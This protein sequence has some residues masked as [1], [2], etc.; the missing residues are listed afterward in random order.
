MTRDPLLQWRH[1]VLPC[2]QMLAPGRGLYEEKM[3]TSNT[4]WISGASEGIDLVTAAFPCLC[5]HTQT[6]DPGDSL[7]LMQTQ[8]L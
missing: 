1:L 2:F 3:G 8:N 4:A 6:Q 5:M 7:N